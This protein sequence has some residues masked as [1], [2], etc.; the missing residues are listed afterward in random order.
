MAFTLEEKARIRHHL[1]YPNVGTMQSFAQGIPLPLQTLFLV[2]G[3]MNKVL[4]ERE[5]Y[6]RVV[7]TDMDKIECQ[8]REARDYM[9]ANKLGDME[10]RKEHAA[11]LK[12]EYADWRMVLADE[13]GVPPYAFSRRSGRGGNIPVRG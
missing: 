13:L 5:D 6:I 3:A 2:D 7:I 8:I 9:V 4:P 11:M 1:G 12:Q 10:I